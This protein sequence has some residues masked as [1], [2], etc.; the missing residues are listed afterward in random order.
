MKN[1]STTI[2]VTILFEEEFYFG[3]DLKKLVKKIE[4]FGGRLESVVKTPTTTKLDGADVSGIRI[5]LTID[6]PIIMYKDYRYIATLTKS[7][8]NEDENIV[9]TVNKQI[10][11]SPYFKAPFHCDHCGTNRRRKKVFIF[12][13]DAGQDLMVASTCGKDYFGI[14]IY[15]EIGNVG[16]LEET[17][18]GFEE[19]ISDGYKSVPCRFD[20]ERLAA[21]SYY[22]I[23]RDKKYISKSKAEETEYSIAYSHADTYDCVSTCDR[24]LS[25]DSAYIRSPKKY[26]DIKN[27][28]KTFDYNKILKYWDDKASKDKSVFTNNIKVSLRQVRPAR[29]MIVYAVY[30]YLKNVEKLWAPKVPEKFKNEF[31]GEVGLRKAF[32]FTVDRVSEHQG[33]KFS[34]YDSGIFYVLK[35]RDPAGRQ[36]SWLTNGH[37][38]LEEG[39]KVK[40]M[41]TVKNHNEYKGYKTTQL[42]HCKILE[43]K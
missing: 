20:S 18:K 14:N 10:D 16:R 2:N 25:L 19:K 23:K 4:K 24:A 42:Y 17:L 3:R 35:F 40:L 29:G 28:L 26:P 34:Y 33:R 43:E 5:E 32:E 6:N 39:N 37:H 41:G 21:F 1:D 31:F 22:V 27:L 36:F 15:K 7:F 8:E 12:R 9:R 38:H 13:N 11:F 30:E